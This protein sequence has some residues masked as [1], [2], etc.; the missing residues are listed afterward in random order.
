MRAIIVDDEPLAR[1]RIN[2]L[3]RSIDQITV[4]KECSNGKSAIESINSLLP[5]LVFLDI[6]MKDMNGFEVLKNINV[7]PK[8]TIIFVTAYDQ[9]AL[10]AFDFEAF[11]FLL[12]PYKEERF[13]QTIDRVL[14][15][16]QRE[17]NHMFERRMRE[18]MVRSID[19]KEEEKPVH[20]H[21]PVRQ[22]NTTVLL[23]PSKIMYVLASGYHAELYTKEKKHVI[24]LSLN[25]LEEN[26]PKKNFFRVSRSAIVN[27]EYIKEIVHSDF[28][29]IDVKMKDDR[30]I[31]ISKLQKKKFLLRLN[32][33][34]V[35]SSNKNS[36]N[37]L[38]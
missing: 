12:K 37:D 17:I 6:N 30:L 28:S 20:A 9:H 11:D 16:S 23:K 36:S 26:L 29:E 32:F 19:S 24:R 7:N 31:S 34:A 10:Q 38:E 22:G 3:L 35:T 8:P 14:H 5:D 27:F 1:K 13:Y 4:V 15:L 18:F 21:L 25:N 33:A 2:S